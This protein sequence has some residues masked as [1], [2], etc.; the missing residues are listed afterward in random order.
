MLK[1]WSKA[2]L[3][4]WISVYINLILK[5]M[6]P[7]FFNECI[8]NAFKL[9]ENQQPASVKESGS[10][11]IGLIAKKKFL[12]ST[13]TS[14]VD[15]FYPKITELA[16]YSNWKVRISICRQMLSISEYVGEQK[17]IELIYPIL[18]NLIEDSE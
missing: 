15:R 5:M 10:F 16:S 12:G 17:T 1:Q 18:K 13:D 11:F 8:D 2:I 9:L 4:E 3:T 7:S 6:Q 14:F